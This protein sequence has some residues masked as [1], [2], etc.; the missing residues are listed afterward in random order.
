MSDKTEEE[1]FEPEKVIEKVEIVKVAK[2]EKAKDIKI[3]KAPKKKRKPLTEERKEQLRE[4]LKRGRAKSKAKRA[5]MKASGQKI[6]YNT[7]KK[8]E[9]KAKAEV[10]ELEQAKGTRIQNNTYNNLDYETFSN[11]MSKYE[12]NKEPAQKINIEVKKKEP[13]FIP[14]KPIPIIKRNI[15][16]FKMP[17][18]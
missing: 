4:Q 14:A 16:G 12:S 2:E 11:Y 17:K 3:V 10:L 6:P 18:W 1:I 7:K 5:A 8:K 13:V 15:G 9:A